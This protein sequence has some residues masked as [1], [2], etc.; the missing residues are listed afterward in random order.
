MQKSDRRVKAISPG[1]C[2]FVQ[3]KNINFHS[4]SCNDPFAGI[5]A[6]EA[7]APIRSVGTLSAPI[8]SVVT[9]SA[10]IRNVARLQRNMALMMC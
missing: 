3:I 6:V 8:R 4:L 5:S 9:L 1:L 10:P 2:L 7:S